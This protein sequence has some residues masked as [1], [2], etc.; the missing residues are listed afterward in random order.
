[1]HPYSDTQNVFLAKNH[2]CFIV[3]HINSTP[4]IVVPSL[5]FERHLSL[6]GD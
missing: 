6:S 1:V 5:D 2:S 4:S 3:V